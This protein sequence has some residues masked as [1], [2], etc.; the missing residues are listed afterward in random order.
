ML[1]RQDQFNTIKIKKQLPKNS[2]AKTALKRLFYV[3]L[4]VVY[5]MNLHLRQQC[6]ISSNSSTEALD[7]RSSN[8][9]LNF[10]Y[11]QSLLFV[12]KMKVHGS[13]KLKGKKSTVEGQ[14]GR[15][16]PYRCKISVMTSCRNSRGHFKLVEG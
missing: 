14:P 11:R 9:K 13:N 6:L 4:R 1:T 16:E 15:G 10:L 3:I 5:L 8:A 7:C 12:L 2:V